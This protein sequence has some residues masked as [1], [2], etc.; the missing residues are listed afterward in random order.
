LGGFASSRDFQPGQVLPA[1]GFTPE[2]AAMAVLRYAGAI[3]E[4]G[5]V[6]TPEFEYFISYLDYLDSEF[7]MQKP[8]PLPR[9][10]TGASNMARNIAN[11]DRDEEK[12][13]RKRMS[14][15]DWTEG[16]M[17]VIDAG[18]QLGQ[19]PSVTLTQLTN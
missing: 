14:A 4:E 10:A 18:I 13:G 9:G 16:Q 11:Q 7:P 17:R 12:T 2:I 3:G 15:K 8:P 5:S 19:K 1:D 6:R